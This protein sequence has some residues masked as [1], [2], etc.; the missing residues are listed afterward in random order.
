[1]KR[2]FRLLTNFVLIILLIVFA[3]I[4]PQKVTLALGFTTLQ[5]PLVVIILIAAFCGFIISS[6]FYLASIWQK[7]RQI[8]VLKQELAAYEQ[9]IETRSMDYV[10]EMR[11]QFERELLEKERD[12]E[13]LEALVRNQ[14][15][16]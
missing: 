8:K 9:E 11:A 5:L 4:N 13:Y 16:E 15:R 1:M 14:E 6:I 12:I 3:I 10:V 2:R 7:Q